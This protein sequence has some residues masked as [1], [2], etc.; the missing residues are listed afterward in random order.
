MPLIIPV[1]FSI[2]I[3]MPTKQYK[4]NNKEISFITAP[5]RITP[6]NKSEIRAKIA[7]TITYTAMVIKSDFDSFVLKLKGKNERNF[8]IIRHS[9]IICF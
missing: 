1:D 9:I 4:A 6:L 5:S 8:L 3:T 2:A 7:G